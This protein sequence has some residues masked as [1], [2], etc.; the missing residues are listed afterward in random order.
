MLKLMGAEHYP[1][2]TLKSALS[3][4][5]SK[6]A[7]NHDAYVLSQEAQE[8]FKRVIGEFVNRQAHVVVVLTPEHSWLRSQEP[9]KLDELFQRLTMGSL[10]KPSTS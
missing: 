7:F 5:E 6:G 10:H 2:L 8:T 9:Q 4:A 1:D 3:S